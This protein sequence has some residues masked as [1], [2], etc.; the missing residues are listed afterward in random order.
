MN[1]IGSYCIL[2]RISLKCNSKGCY[3]R[4]E[5]CTRFGLLTLLVLDGD[6]IIKEL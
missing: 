2:C 4:N 6:G 3:C 5:M 1:W